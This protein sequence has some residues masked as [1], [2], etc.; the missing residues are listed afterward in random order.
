[1]QMDEVRIATEKDVRRWIDASY[2]PALELGVDQKRDLGSRTAAEVAD[3][4]L[5]WHHSIAF[6][7]TFAPIN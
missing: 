4:E 7:D 2:G 3:R 6:I 1:K 5:G